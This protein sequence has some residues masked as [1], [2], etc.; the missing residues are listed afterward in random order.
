[1][2]HVVRTRD[3]SFLFKHRQRNTWHAIF[4]THLTLTLQGLGP[5]QLRCSCPLGADTDLLDLGTQPPRIRIQNWDR[6]PRGLWYD[7]TTQAPDPKPD[8][9]R[10]K[11]QSIQ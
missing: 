1:M 9:K 3:A 5:P 10:G 8:S 11:H 6:T 4:E 2:Y 7:G